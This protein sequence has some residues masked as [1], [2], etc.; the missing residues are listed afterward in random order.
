M[1]FCHH[2][3][4]SGC[5]RGVR[6]LPASAS[7]CQRCRRCILPS[8]DLADQVLMGGAPAAGRVFTVFFNRKCLVRQLQFNRF[9]CVIGTFVAVLASSACSGLQA[10]PQLQP[11]LVGNTLDQHGCNAS[12]GAS[13]CVKEKACVQPWVLSA[14]KGFE[15]G[16]KAAFDAYCQAPAPAPTPTPA[17]APAPAPPP[18]PVVGGQ[19]DAH[20]CLPA[21]GYSW[22][23]KEN[24]C[25]RPWE[26]SA[27]K[28]FPNGDK[29]AFDAYC[30]ASAK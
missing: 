20:G 19:R 21:A 25:V 17:S 6:I 18:M 27:Q 4:F 13:W 29:A 30:T 22:C 5:P 23:A 28:G 2:C 8:A 14:Q 26:L 3:S 24:A 10:A 12:T 15:K 7:F 9:F 16:N 11:P 1:I